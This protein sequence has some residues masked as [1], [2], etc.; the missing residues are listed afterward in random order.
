M[1]DFD[2]PDNGLFDP[3]MRWVVGH[4]LYGAANREATDLLHRVIE[5]LQDRN[6]AEVDEV[7]AS[8]IDRATAAIHAI[9]ATMRYAASLTPVIYGEQV[10]PTMA[11]PRCPN[12]LTGGQNLDHAAYRAAIAGFLAQ[13]GTGY[14]E[15]ARTAPQCAR[16]RDAL[17]QADLYDLEEHVAL[18]YALVGSAAAIDEHDHGSAV[19]AL[20]RMLSART[21]KYSP[22][23]RISVQW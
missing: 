2:S 23:L 19:A 5:I 4:Q 20:R 16:A 10:R 7:V 15:L 21:A 8:V 22:M 3:N 12:E 13:L 9:T 18:T 6:V 17:L 1:T 11:P 14:N